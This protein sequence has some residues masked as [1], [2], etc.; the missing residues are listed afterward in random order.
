MIRTN[1]RNDAEDELFS[2]QEL[3]RIRKAQG[4][5][6]ESLARVSGLATV[7]IAKLEEG[8][9]S[10][11]KASTLSKLAGALGCRLDQL[12][13]TAPSESKPIQPTE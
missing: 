13:A 9:N 10:D 12:F 7:T 8:R 2:G 5:T 1:V 4:L 11:P 6:Q 3:A